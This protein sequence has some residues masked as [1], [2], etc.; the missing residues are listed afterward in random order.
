M[1]DVCPRLC[2][3]YGL[4]AHSDVLL[5]RKLLLQEQLSICLPAAPDIVAPTCDQRLLSAELLSQAELAVSL[6]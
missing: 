2:M 3:C 5:K 1:T 4:F 6:A